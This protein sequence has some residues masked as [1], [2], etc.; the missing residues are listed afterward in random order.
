MSSNR[1]IMGKWTNSRPVTWLGWFVVLI[2]SVAGAAAI[3]TLL[4]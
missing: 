3:I 1:K 4:T 2:M